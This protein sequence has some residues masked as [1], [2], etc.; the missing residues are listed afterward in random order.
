METPR[1]SPV[2]D[3]VA[4]LLAWRRVVLS[5]A[6]GAIVVSLAYALLA[7]PT[8]LARTTLLPKQEE[9]QFPGLSSLVNNDLAAFAGV[10]GGA[11]SDSDLLLTILES[12][13]LRDRLIDRLDLVSAFGIKVTTPARA[14]ETAH[15]RL[16]K[17]MKVGLT[18]RLSIFV[19]VRAGSAELAA[20][21]ANAAF[22]ELDRMNQEFA[23]T[24]ARQTR[25]FIE[26]RLK[27]TRDSLATATAELAEFQRTNRMVAIDEQARAAVDVASRLQAELI[28]L[29]A[30]LDVQRRYSTGSYSRTRDLEYRIAALR[31]RLGQLLGGGATTSGG[32][33]PAGGARGGLSA[34]DEAPELLMS[35]QEIPGLGRRLAEILLDVKTQEAVFLLL[36]TQHQQARI[37]EARDVPT[38]QVLDRAEPPV[39]RDAPR[40]RQV[41]MTG[42][43]AGAA[44]GALLAFAFE[45]LLRAF[46]GPSGERLR[47]LLGPRFGGLE[48]WL[49][50]TRS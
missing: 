40:R 21:I 13:H 2:L 32:G 10:L 29:E 33:G 17:A 47:R 6:V 38:I 39:F 25:H 37:D 35:F 34:G 4:V 31:G 14:R 45:Y 12:R 28:G 15:A 5:F 19:E 42:A 41:V 44:G 46:R 30:Q 16:E 50:R 20:N 36:T 11:S 3:F 26:Q 8:Y 22:E 49:A 48:G 24:S 27:E 23:F 1:S 7:R 9:G 43:F 18:K